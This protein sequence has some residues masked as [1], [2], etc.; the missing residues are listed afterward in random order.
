[1][2]FLGTMSLGDFTQFNQY[3]S[4]ADLP[5]PDIG[6]MSNLIAQ[7]QASFGRISGVL[8]APEPAEKGTL[9]KEL[10]GDIELTDVGDQFCGKEAL[11]EVSFRV[12]GGSKTAVIGPTAAGKT[13]LLYLLTGLTKPEKGQHRHWTGSRSMSIKKRI[14]TGR[15]DSSSR[16]VSSSI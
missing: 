16:T 14:F 15:S 8:N 11:K 10:N 5:D 3:L 1:M 4:H 13:Q 9:V 7:A 2:L 12:K 6:F